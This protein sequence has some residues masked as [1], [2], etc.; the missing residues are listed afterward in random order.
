MSRDGVLSFLSNFESKNYHGR[1]D[2]GL[3][4]LSSL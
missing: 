3:S 4:W 2:D 1:S